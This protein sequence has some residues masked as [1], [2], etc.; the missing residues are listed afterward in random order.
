[1][2]NRIKR[3]NLKSGF[4]FRTLRNKKDTR[5]GL[6]G[7]LKRA[8]EPQGSSTSQELS[9]FPPRRRTENSGRTKTSKKINLVEQK[10]SKNVF[11]NAK[12]TSPFYK[13]QPEVVCIPEIEKKSKIDAMRLS[14]KRGAQKTIFLQIC[15]C[16]VA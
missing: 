16:F 8:T 10:W 6:S 5:P 2:L 1:M 3:S 13:L 11:L 12:L 9:K 15:P 4:F 7:S 14:A